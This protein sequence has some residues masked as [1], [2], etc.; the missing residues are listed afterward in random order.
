MGMQRHEPHTDQEIRPLFNAAGLEPLVSHATAGRWRCRCLLCG[1]VSD[2][3]TVRN[4]KRKTRHGCQQCAGKQRRL[5]HVDAVAVMAAADLEPLESYP[6]HAGA[7]WRCRCLL[8]GADVAARYSVVGQGGGCCQTCGDA[9]TSQTSRERKSESAVACVVAAGYSPLVAYP[10]SLVRWPA[11]HDRCGREVSILHS[12]IRQGGGCCTACAQF[13]LDRTAPAIVYLFKFD[14]LGAVKVGV[15]NDRHNRLAK[16]RRQGG[17][18]I[19][20]WNVATGAEAERI[21]NAILFDFWRDECDAPEGCTPDE[22]PD[23][24]TETA[25]SAWPGVEGTAARIEALVA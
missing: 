23:G 21:E 18:L 15:S 5:R 2:T 25:P 17:E 6:G 20:A 13:G 24:Y 16:H 8:C 9:G 10:G 4:V 14:R 12:T 11:I 3:T 7:L 1:A 19:A 22:L